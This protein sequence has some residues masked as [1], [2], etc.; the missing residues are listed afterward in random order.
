MN[1]EIV[2]TKPGS[3]HRGD[4]MYELDDCMLVQRF[5]SNLQS[6]LTY[7]DVPFPNHP[8]NWT[9]SYHHE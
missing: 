7:L 3:S 1:V 5:T 8:S 2:H 4:W 9:D 6:K